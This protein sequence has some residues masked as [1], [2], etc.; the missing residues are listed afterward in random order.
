MVGT[1]R[2][3]REQHTKCFQ[4]HH[5]PKASALVYVV[6]AVIAR[7]SA[8]KSR[9]AYQRVFYRGLCTTRDCIS[10]GQ[11]NAYVYFPNSFRRAKCTLATS[12]LGRFKGATLTL[13]HTDCTSGGSPLPLSATTHPVGSETG[14]LHT[15]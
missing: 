2:N 1:G 10:G 4:T 6:E 13:A 8:L 12:S 14:C 5:E 3:A 9:K 11:K 7:P 15:T